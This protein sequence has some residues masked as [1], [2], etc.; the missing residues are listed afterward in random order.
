MSLVYHGGFLFS[1]CQSQQV[2]S[3]EQQQMLDTD[4]CCYYYSKFLFSSQSEL[5]R[6][7]LE[8]IS[9]AEFP[10]YQPIR[11][12]LTQLMKHILVS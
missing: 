5:L 8:G 3:M 4:C 9:H 12:R 1:Y 2:L 11:I 6:Q 10:T 7:L